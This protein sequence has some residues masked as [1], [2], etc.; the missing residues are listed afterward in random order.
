MKR[1]AFIRK[2]QGVDLAEL[3][4]ERDPGDGPVPPELYQEF[5]AALQAGH[6]KVGADWTKG[7]VAL[8]GL[9]ASELFERWERRNGRRPLVLAMCAG[10]GVAEGVWLERGYNVT[11]HDCQMT[12]LRDL[13]ARFPDTPTLIADIREIA[14][15]SKFDLILIL[16]SEYFLDT[17]ELE[18]LM[19]KVSDSLTPDGLFVLH[20]VSVLSVRQ[21][22]SEIL[23]K[24]IGTYRAATYLFWGWWRTPY[25]FYRCARGAGLTLL[26]ASTLVTSRGGYRS[27]QRRPRISRLWTTLSNPEVVMVFGLDRRDLQDW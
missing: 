3:A 14:I 15:A 24:A 2:W 27:M 4:G 21:W 26:S 7:K 9:V 22:L 11:L 8:G 18:Q 23:K 19:R 10:Q 20:S 12:S 13:C 25:E 17:A 5:Y 1:P 16:A 6:G